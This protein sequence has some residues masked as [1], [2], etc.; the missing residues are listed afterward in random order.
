MWWPASYPIYLTIGNISKDVRR[1]ATQRA[2]VI[3]GYSPVEGFRDVTN[4]KVWTKL[5]GDLLNRA[6]RMITEPLEEARR[7]GV[8]MWCADGLSEEDIP[9]G[10]GIHR[11]LARAEQHGVYVAERLSQ[12][13][14]RKT[15]D[16][17]MCDAR[18]HGAH[19][20]HCRSW[21]RS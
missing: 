9:I 12:S 21:I 16:E 13:A 7:T 18:R 19:S 6:M 5:R 2:S 3:L 14:A 11:G 15:K 20:R 17:G 4:E 8:D 10:C 1:K